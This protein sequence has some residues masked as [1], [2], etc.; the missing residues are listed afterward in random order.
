VQPIAVLAELARA[1]GV[2]FHTDAVQGAGW[3]DTRLDVLGVDALSVSGHKLG[4]PK[5]IGALAVRQRLLLEPVVHGGGQERGHRSGTENVAFA[6]GLAR[7][8]TLSE[9]GRQVAAERTSAL[10]DE[11]IRAVLAEIPDALLTGH[12]VERLPSVASFCFPGTSGEAVLLQLEE[13]GIVVSSGS[14]CAAGSDDP[15][16]VLLALGLTP[17]I[18]QTAVRFTLTPDTTAEELSTTVR[19]LVAAVAEVSALG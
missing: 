4:A 19:S 2:P 16:P 13:R 11:F 18:A 7:A 1:S 14:A 17:Q 15:S 8:V 9:P 10:R 12:P 3:L 5:G 6:V